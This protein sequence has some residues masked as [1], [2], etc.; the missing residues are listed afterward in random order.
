ME[1]KSTFQKCG[2]LFLAS[3]IGEATLHGAHRLARLVVIKPDAL[4]AELRVDDVDIIPLAD[5]FVRALG[6]ASAAVD[7]VG[8]DMRGH[9]ASATLGPPL[10]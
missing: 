9:G 10:S 4:R 8:R 7:A 2:L 1:V 5:G 6:L 3:R